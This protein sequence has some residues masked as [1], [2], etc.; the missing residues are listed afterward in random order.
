MA[1]KKSRASRRPAPRTAA[2]GKRARAAESRG[3]GR[4][5]NK[6]ARPTLS[7]KTSAIQGMT[8]AHDFVMRA[9]QGFPD[10]K[11]C[12]QNSPADNH[13]VW[14]LG[15]LATGYDWLAGLLDGKPSQLSEDTQKLFGSASKPQADASI[16]PP[17]EQIRATCDSAWKRL[18]RAAQNSSDTD[19]ASAPVSPTGGFA[20]TR[21]DV[22]HRVAWHDGWHAGQVSTLRRALGLPGLM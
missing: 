1:K 8:F 15:H 21:L 10:D 12:H 9:C 3:K 22:I 14:T 6:P 20:K 11:L 18:L 19:L 2:H 7:A 17:L 4:P 5:A 13:P 16:Y